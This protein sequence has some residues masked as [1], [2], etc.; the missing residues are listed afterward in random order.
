MVHSQLSDG[1]ITRWCTNKPHHH[2]CTPTLALT[3][4]DIR[5]RTH[6]T[7][8]P[9][10][11]VRRVAEVGADP[12]LKVTEPRHVRW[13]VVAIV[14]G[15]IADARVGGHTDRYPRTLLGSGGGQSREVAVDCVGDRIEGTIKVGALT[16]RERL[17][18]IE[19]SDGRCRWG[20][21]GWLRHA[22]I[23]R[24]TR[25]SRWRR[26]RWGWRRGR[27]GRRQAGQRRPVWRRWRR[28]PKDVMVHSQLS[29]GEIT[30]W[31]TNKPHHHKCTPTLALTIHDI[32]PRT[33]G[34]RAPTAKVRRVAEVGADPDLKVT[35]PRH[36]RWDVVAI[37]H[38]HIADA[39]VGGHTDR[40]PR[41]L[42][43]SG[44]G[45][46][47]EVAVDGMGG[48]VFGRAEVGA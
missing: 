39:R 28:R 18:A 4:H 33:H 30:R 10:A 41:T 46:S 16:Q 36:V 45:Q 11:K 44:G 9:T 20:R 2:K 29:D 25:R 40:Y 6:G 34:T 31:C 8:A 32:R 48:R 37:V 19:G 5:P 14:H 15:H 22:R 42:L 38:G 24:G 27:W 43:G 12:D 21:C 17:S 26:R 1:E 47:R 13:D 23:W 35:E 3:I 7:R